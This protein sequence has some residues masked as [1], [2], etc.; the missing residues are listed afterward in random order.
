MDVPF[1]NFFLTQVLGR[2]RA[3]CYSFLDELAT[4]DR[5]LCKSLTYIKVGDGFHLQH[6]YLSTTMA[7][8]LS[9]S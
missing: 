6:F 3:S 1:A 2:Q 5:D 8:F 4:L 7:M 9:W